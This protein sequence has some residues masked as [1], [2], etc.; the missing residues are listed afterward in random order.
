MLLLSLGRTWEVKERLLGWI[1]PP[2]APGGAAKEG[3]SSFTSLCMDLLLRSHFSSVLSKITRKKEMGEKKLYHHK[4][5]F[6]LLLV[7]FIFITDFS[8]Q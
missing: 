1:R 5:H 3:K 2:F 4:T 8:K 7:F 6:L